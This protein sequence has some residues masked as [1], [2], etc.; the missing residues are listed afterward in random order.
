ME[1][2][3]E[4]LLQPFTAQEETERRCDIQGID[5]SR[6][7]PRVSHLL[8]AENTIIFVHARE[9]TMSA[10]KQILTAYGKASGQEINF[11]KSSMVV[12]Q[13]VGDQERLRIAAILGVA[14]VERHDKYLGLRTVVGQSRGELFLTIKDRM[15]G[16]IQGWNTKLLSQ[17]GCGVLINA[18]LQSIPTYVMSC[19]RLPDYLLHEIEMMIAEFWWHNK[20]ECRTHWIGWSRLCQPRDESGPNFKENEGI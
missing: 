7:A 20:G 16:R 12:S 3:N 2:M 11:E 13:N 6:E 15:W 10:I 8:F 1:A 5:I 17:A 19:F 9:E 18:V 4:F 14:L